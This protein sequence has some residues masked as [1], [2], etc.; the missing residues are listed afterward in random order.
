MSRCFG[1]FLGK[2]MVHFKVIRKFQKQSKEYCNCFFFFF[3]L[4]NFNF[5]SFLLF[6]FKKLIY[7]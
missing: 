4:F 1:F 2:S 6:N 7:S 3:H 5:I